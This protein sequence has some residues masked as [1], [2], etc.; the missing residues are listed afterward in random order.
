MIQ[1]LSGSSVSSTGVNPV[2]VLENLDQRVSVLERLLKKGELPPYELP[3]F[4]EGI[5]L[6]EKLINSLDLV[7]SRSC[8][9]KPN[10]FRNV[11][12]QLYTEYDKEIRDKKDA[13]KWIKKVCESQCQRD[14]AGQ[15]ELETYKNLVWV[16]SN[17][18]HLVNRSEQIYDSLEEA[19]AH[20]LARDIQKQELY[21]AA[22]EN[23]AIILNAVGSFVPDL[24]VHAL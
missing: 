12:R 22:T 17:V 24:H 14:T 20:K 23:V 7:V 19:K 11:A 8:Y 16:S 4:R 13:V 5:R 9:S 18:L 15:M 6:C 1:T 3:Y 21:K 2:N 10:I